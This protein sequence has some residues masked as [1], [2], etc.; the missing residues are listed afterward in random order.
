MPSN[1]S[2]MPSVAGERPARL[3][4]L[5]DVE[6]VMD[7]YLGDGRA[8]RLGAPVSCSTAGAQFVK[9]GLHGLDHV[10]ADGLGMRLV[11]T[12]Y[13]LADTLHFGRF[14]LVE[15]HPGLL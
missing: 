11:D 7:A 9:G 13:R 4:W 2:P 8:H 6:P 15:L 14:E 10:A 12:G 5:E 3:E 1:I